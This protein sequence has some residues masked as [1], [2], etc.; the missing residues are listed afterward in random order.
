MQVA[1]WQVV[2]GV[3]GSAL[4]GSFTTEVAGWLRRRGQE[5]RLARDAVQ[6]AARE[7]IRTALASAED[8]VLRLQGEVAVLREEAADLR[9]QIGELRLQH[10]ECEQRTAELQREID[11]LMAGPVPG[12]ATL[13]RARTR[14]EPTPRKGGA[15]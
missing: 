12:Y 6:E 2:A 15:S 10:A 14:T 4:G 3:I 11:R 7:L 8:Q 5:R 9:R 13:K 1:E